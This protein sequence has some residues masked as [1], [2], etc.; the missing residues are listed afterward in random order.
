MNH[1]QKTIEALPDCSNIL[2]FDIDPAVWVLL[3]EGL[4]DNFFKHRQIPRHL[5]FFIRCNFH[6]TVSVALL[7]PEFHFPSEFFPDGSPVLL[8][9]SNPS[10]R[11]DFDADSVS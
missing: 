2:R 5:R 6:P 11:N 9:N 4:S 10:E 1:V 8:R 7:L 3:S